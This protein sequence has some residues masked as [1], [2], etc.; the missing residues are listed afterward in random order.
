MSRV[1][2]RCTFSGHRKLYDDFD[3]GQLKEKI[4]QLI[5]NGTKVFYDGMAEGFD[6]KAA[7]CVLQLKESYPYIQLVACLPYEKKMN[8]STE[9]GKLYHQVLNACDKKIVISKRFYEGCLLERDRYMVDNSDA[10]LYYLR[11]REGGTYYTVNYAIKRGIQL[12]EL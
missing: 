2:E 6:L 3:V 5:L 1:Y 4:E 10:I 7:E 9:E 8:P 12:F 11:K